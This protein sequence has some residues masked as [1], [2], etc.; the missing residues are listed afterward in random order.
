MTLIQKAKDKR[1]ELELKLVV[2]TRELI[3]A[4]REIASLQVEIEHLEEIKKKYEAR[5]AEDPSLATDMQKRRAFV[6]EV[7]PQ[8][9]QSQGG[10]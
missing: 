7:M 9:R 8:F 10:Q 1:K 6:K 3:I 5:L 2:T 4:Q